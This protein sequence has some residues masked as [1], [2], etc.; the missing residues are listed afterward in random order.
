M[1]RINR[2]RKLMEKKGIE[3]F[4]SEN[5]LDFFYLLGFLCTKGVLFVTMQEAFFFLDSRYLNDLKPLALTTKLQLEDKAIL[6]KVNAYPLN[7]KIA[8]SAKKFSHER[9]IQL[10]NGLFSNRQEHLITIDLVEILRI[11]KDLTEIELLKKAAILTKKSFDGLNIEGV[12][13][14]KALEMQFKMNL[15]SQGADGWSFDPIIAF[16]RHAASPHYHPS[17][18]IMKPKEEIL[19][20]CGAKVGQYNG[21][22]TRTLLLNAA[23]P[24]LK[25]LFKIVEES[26]HMIIQ[27]IRPGL[28]FIELTTKIHQFFAKHQVEDLFLHSLGHGIGLDLHE[29]PFFK[30]HPSSELEIKEN[31][32]FTIEPGLYDPKVGGVRYENTIWMSESGPVS[33]TE[34]K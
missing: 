29:M 16:D 33:L 1:N 3:G 23:S 12:N 13:C 22:M 8:F 4:Y 11:E 34:E 30:N 6:E 9:A 31:M 7:K 5:P 18:E 15:L 28:K 32:V 10:L 26:Y 17:H 2:L 25:E 20:D 14:E 24:K 27:Q 21:D 19:I